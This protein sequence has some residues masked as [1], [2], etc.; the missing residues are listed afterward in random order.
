M[1]KADKIHTTNSEFEAT[2]GYLRGLRRGEIVT[3]AGITGFDYSSMQISPELD[4]QVSMALINMENSLISLGANK[5]DLVRLNW[6]IT[7]RE[8]FE[9]AGKIIKEYFEGTAPPATT[10]IVGLVD[11]R[12]LFELEATALTS[13]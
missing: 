13:K 7:R 6:F 5:W 3:L 4:N 12:M 9:P 10:T 1:L 2:A 8:L 11:E